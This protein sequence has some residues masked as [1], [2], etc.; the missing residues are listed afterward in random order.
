MIQ[1]QIPRKHK[2]TINTLRNSDFTQDNPNQIA[3]LISTRPTRY[4]GVSNL[5]SRNTA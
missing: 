2:V 1:Y 5:V 3:N 4:L